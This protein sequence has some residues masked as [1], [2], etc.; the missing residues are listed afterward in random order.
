MVFGCIAPQA[1]DG[2]EQL[3]DAAG[4]P[5][6]GNVGSEILHRKSPRLSGQA[7]IQLWQSVTGEAARRLKDVSSH[8]RAFVGVPVAF[9]SVCNQRIIVWPDRSAVVRVRVERRM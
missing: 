8:P 7:G 6:L 3:E 9:E 5:G 1:E 4:R 2:L